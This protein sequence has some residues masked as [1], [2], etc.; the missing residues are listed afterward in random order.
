[1]KEKIIEKEKMYYIPEWDRKLNFRYE[2]HSI[3]KGLKPVIRSIVGHILDEA[4]NVKLS[5]F[6]P[7]HK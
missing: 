3:I 6:D 5:H 4:S 7:K 1:M 2:Q